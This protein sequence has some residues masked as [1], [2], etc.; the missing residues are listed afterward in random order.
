MSK[1]ETKPAPEPSKV[2]SGAGKKTVSKQQAEGLKQVAKL[3]SIKHPTKA[4]VFI[5]RGTDDFD[6]LARGGLGGDPTKELA[7]SLKKE[8][9]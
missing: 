8:N 9:K 7:A 3:K 2:D 4:G 5:R 6:Q 1:T